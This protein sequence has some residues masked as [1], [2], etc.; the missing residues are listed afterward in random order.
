RDDVAF[1]VYDLDTDQ[2]E[3]IVT[4]LTTHEFFFFEDDGAKVIGMLLNGKSLESV[5]SWIQQ[6]KKGDT[7][8][9][10]HVA[11]AFL[12][13]YA[14]KFFII[15]GVERIF[16]TQEKEVTPYVWRENDQESARSADLEMEV[17]NRFNCRK[18]IILCSAELTWNCNLR[19][20]HCYNPT[21]DTTN[22]LTKEDWF[23]VIRQLRAQGVYRAILTGG[24]PLCYPYFWD[25][26]EE[27][28]RNH[29]AFDV[30][31]NGQILSDPEKVSRLAELHPRSV[32]CSLYGIK[33]ETH[34]FITTVPGSWE[35]TVRC[36]N[37]FA[38]KQIPTLIKA[39][40]MK[41]NY[42]ELDDLAIFAQSIKA[43]LQV[44]IGLIRKLDGN[45]APLSLRLDEDEMMSVMKN[46]HLPLYQQT[47]NLKNMGSKYTPP[48]TSLCTAGR[49]TI[50][51][52]YDGTVTP[53]VSYGVSVGSVKNTRL[54]EILKSPELLRVQSLKRS[55]RCK[56]CQACDMGG[57]CTFCPANSLAEKGDALAD[58]SLT[59]QLVQAYKK[60]AM[61]I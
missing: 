13:E 31:T 30:Y 46:K 26:A 20:Q 57:Y 52:R 47:N 55:D 39:I 28:H 6:N 61:E 53:C 60:S 33:P 45:T 36:L 11:M 7:L 14:S 37:L 59:C 10:I 25:V 2:P 38:D 27:M 8:E 22:L 5:C 18:K 43:M 35:K 54:S 34:D 12:E 16:S 1:G 19:C 41:P 49:V 40:G 9:N 21:H 42:Q 48:E 58:C 17:H 4:Q 50:N 15:D 44:D 56:K 51:I 23:S 24:D 29:M 3:V 32:Q